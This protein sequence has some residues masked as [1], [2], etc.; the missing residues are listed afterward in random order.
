MLIV[1]ILMS[2]IAIVLAVQQIIK[3]HTADRLL[4]AM[5]GLIGLFVALFAQVGIIG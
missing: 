1:T 2:C 5:L 3:I 4:M